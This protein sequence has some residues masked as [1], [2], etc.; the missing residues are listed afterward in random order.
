[1]TEPHQNMSKMAD[2]K[3]EAVFHCMRCHGIQRPLPPPGWAPFLP[4][5]QRLAHSSSWSDN[6]HLLHHSQCSSSTG[7]ILIIEPCNGELCV[8]GM[9]PSEETG[10]VS[11]WPWLWQNLRAP[12]KSSQL[13][14][15]PEPQILGL[16]ARAGKK[17]PG[18][19]L[20]HNGKMQIQLQIQLQ[21]Q[22]NP[23]VLTRTYFRIREFFSTYRCT[24]HMYVHKHNCMYISTYTWSL[25][26]HTCVLAHKDW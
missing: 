17:S 12:L 21:N 2:G 4:L 6:Q 5:V 3:T 14:V 24:K 8:P 1:M 20:A 9:L 18:L 25:F 19:L 23:G 15:G 16:G 11:G 10:T 22:P 7:C 26:L 13:M